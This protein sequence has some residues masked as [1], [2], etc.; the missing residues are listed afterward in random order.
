MATSKST[1]I[2]FSEK[3]HNLSLIFVT[4]KKG[5]VAVL[6]RIDKQAENQRYVMSI[7]LTVDGKS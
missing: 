5:S 2:S 6:E 4:K 7:R 3:L 1:L